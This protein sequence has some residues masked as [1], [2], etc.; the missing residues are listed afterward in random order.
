MTEILF[1]RV[2]VATKKDLQVFATKTEVN[3]QEDRLTAQAEEISQLRST[4]QTQEARLKQVESLCRDN[5]NLPEV[6]G[7]NTNKYG[8][9]LNDSSTRR[10]NLV[11]HGIHKEVDADLIAY[12]IA[13]GE[14]LGLVVY[15]EDIQAITRLATRST[16][17]TRPPPVLVSFNRHFLRDNFLR[18]KYRL[19]DKP[20]YSEVYINADEPTDV[21]RCKGLYRRIA[22]NGSADGETV[23]MRQD[24]ICIGDIMYYPTDLDKIPSK[25]MPTN[26]RVQPPRSCI[27]DER[28][29][30]TLARA[31]LVSPPVAE[32]IRLT[33]A[34]LIFSGMTAFLSNLSRAEFVYEGT[35][36]TYTEQGLHHLG[37]AHHLDFDLAERILKEDDTGKIKEMLH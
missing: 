2:N 6:Q 36:Y 24:W 11:I 29:K 7:Q 13:I 25:S 15:R 33:K 9:R 27:Q 4:T 19:V 37:A 5:K 16:D 35:P 1:L 18:E 21:R 12:I 26:Q 23:E 31:K 8:A 22:S 3:D 17:P 10:L 32:R 30:D 34:G 28:Y 14:A 20:N